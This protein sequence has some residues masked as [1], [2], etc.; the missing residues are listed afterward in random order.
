MGLEIEYLP[1]QTPLDHDELEGLKIPTITTRG[2]LDEFE[3]QNIEHAVEWTL[4]NKFKADKIL[5]VEF[6][7]TLHKRML[8]E[9]WRWAG[10]FRTTNKNLGVD[11][12]EIP[13]ELRNLIDDTKYWI[14]K[15]VFKPDEIAIRFSHR[16]VKIHPFPNGNGRHSRLIGDILA[17]HVF[18]HDVFS[19]G[20]ENLETKG[21]ARALYLQALHEADKNNYTKL[22]HFARQ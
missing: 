2:E 13:I 17:N 1:G 7:K 21:E 6:I 3:Q 22:I 15:S 11:K 10:E 19:W 4:K 14:E 20:G 8:G 9:V 5:T 12:F 16:I 18:S